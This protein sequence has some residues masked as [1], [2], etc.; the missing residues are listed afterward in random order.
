MRPYIYIISLLCVFSLEVSAQ[1]S[2]ETVLH[3]IEL[4]N[5]SLKAYRE[6]ADAEKI[7]N[8]TGL[9][10][11]NPEVDFSYLWGSPRETTKQRYNI[12]VTQSFDFPTAYRYK[13]QLANEK[14]KQVDLVYDGQRRDILQQAR[15]L[16][17]ELVY[18]MKMNTQ[19]SERLTYAKELYDAY[20]KSF[21]KGDISILERNK[22]QLNYLNE[23]KAL[24]MNEV[25]IST[26]KRD[27]ERL[28]GGIKLDITPSEYSKYILPLDFAEWFQQIR[29]NNP[30]I[31]L[32]RQE[33]TLSKK[34]EQLTKALNL[35]KLKAGYTSER[36]PGETHQGVTVGVS[37]PLWENKN[38]VKYQK[39]QTMA[40]EMQYKDSE[41]LFQNG[42]LN[43]YQRASKLNILLKEYQKTLDVANN[44]D[45][46]K[47]ALDKGQISLINYLLELAVVYETIDK[48]LETEKEYHLAVSELKQWDL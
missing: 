46:L 27:L 30:A 8:R 6:Q 4:N 24:Q 40:L 23:E 38:T 1:S 29:E 19:L 41:L 22:A 32:A 17:V 28:N 14:D 33:I 16:C 35:P 20:Q 48:Y 31:G 18:Q 45:L 34:Q 36:S 11:P 37:I 13:S 10:I 44:R 39:A 43:Q 9:N 12:D 26:I 2:I 15:T 42:L 7:G 5:T 21:D 25:E 47:K 3:E